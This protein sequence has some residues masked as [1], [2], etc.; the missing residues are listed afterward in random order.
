VRYFHRPLLRVAPWVL[1]ALALTSCGAAPPATT[2]DQAAVLSAP[3]A[4]APTTAPPAPT[5][6]PFVAT[7]SVAT[8]SPVAQA[9]VATTSPAES[10]MAPGLVANWDGVEALLDRRVPELLEELAVPGAVIALVHNG[11]PAYARG[12]GFADVE[13]GRPMATDTVFQAASI[14]KTVTAWGVMRLVD[15]GL[16]E[17]DAPVERYL[18]RWRLP[19]SEF[20]HEGVTL[21]RILSHTAGLTLHGYPG[22]PPGEPLPT[23][24]ESLD[25]GHPG[26]EPVRVQSEPGTAYAYSGGGYTLLQL[27]VEEVT[28]ELFA[29]YM[30]RE[31]LQPLGMNR[32][33]YTWDAALQPDT[34]VGYSREGQALPNYLFIEQGPASLYS[35]AD[36][37]ARFAAAGLPGPNGEPPGRGVLAPATLE[38]MYSPAENTEEQSYGLG[39]Q[40][41]VF[42]P[43]IIGHAGSN[44]GWKTF[45]G[46]IPA[47]AE[48]VVVLTNG[49]NGR[50]L[51]AALIEELAGRQP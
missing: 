30:R 16:L 13:G 39:Y 50:N 18:T 7:E 22:I 43:G 11:E 6:T 31:I 41:N 38:L 19:P 8:S 26:T 2:S 42:G 23:L 28:G 10:G 44:Q 4:V 25:G 32:S 36:D 17:L 46:V 24:E 33:S 37:L 14:S 27:V 21:R 35:T 51:R 15:Q 47:T 1:A 12:Y 9:S 3:S 29:D 40:M 20:D 49:D 45:F 48:G 5:F 34:A